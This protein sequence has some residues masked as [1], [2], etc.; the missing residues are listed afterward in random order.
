MLED[1][2]DAGY[3]DDV[4]SKLEEIVEHSREYREGLVWIAK[5]AVEGDWL[6]SLGLKEEKIFINMIRLLGQTFNDI[7]NKREVS[8]NRKLNRQIQNFLFK[9]GRLREFLIEGKEKSA[10]R[11]FTLL[12]AISDIDPVVRR[13]LKS[14]VEKTFPGIQFFGDQKAAEVLTASSSRYFFTLASSLADKQKELKNIVEVEIPKNSKEIGA[15]IELGDLS[16]N[17]E[18]KAGKEKQ[19]ALQIQVGK[20]KDELERARPFSKDDG[21]PGKIGFGMKIVLDDLI[22]KKEDVYTILGPWESDPSAKVI[23]YLS[24][25]GS[26]FIGRE[27]G[28]ELD[29]TINDRRYNYAIKNVEAIKLS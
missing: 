12:D 6:V 15:A 23:S 19:E 26:A 10:V 14:D 24:P 3:K 1:L 11:V 13:D 9:E 17:A 20:L 4:L 8:F 2:L 16:E 5:H 28:D 21:E 7:E 18:Y 22:E 29:F 27:E 25:F